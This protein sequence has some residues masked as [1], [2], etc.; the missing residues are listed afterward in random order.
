MNTCKPRWYTLVNVQAISA[1]IML[2][3][4]LTILQKMILNVE[5]E[6]RNF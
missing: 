6:E 5:D 3:C 4:A 1:S 2:T